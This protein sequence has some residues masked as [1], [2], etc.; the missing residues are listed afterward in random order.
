[1]YPLGYLFELLSAENTT[2]FY[3]LLLT[4]EIESFLLSFTNP[5]SV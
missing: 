4:T 2:V 1:M 5:Y 3:V